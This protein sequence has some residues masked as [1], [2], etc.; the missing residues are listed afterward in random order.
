MAQVIVRQIDGQSKQPGPKAS[1]RI[2]LSKPFPCSQ[3]CFLN[4]VS[5]RFLIGY[6]SANDP[7]HAPL[8]SLNQFSKSILIA[9]SSCMDKA[10]LTGGHFV[11]VR[12]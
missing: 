4:Q 1:S 6:K 11:T 8:V 12:R 10:R 2:K 3:E 7:S 9:Q 5:D